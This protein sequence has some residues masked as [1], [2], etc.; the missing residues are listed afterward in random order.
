VLVPASEDW[1]TGDQ[2]SSVEV[3]DEQPTAGS[4][5]LQILFITMELKNWDGGDAR[6][7]GLF[8]GEIC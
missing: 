6:R 8:D 2:V 4:K 3:A 1:R 5:I 7:R